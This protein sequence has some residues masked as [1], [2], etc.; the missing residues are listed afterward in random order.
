MQEKILTVTIHDCEVQTFRVGGHGGQKVN[1]TSSGVR[2]IHHP[3]NARG[4]C[5]EH[6]EQSRNKRAAFVKMA[7]SLQFKTWVGQVT[8]NLKTPSQI[9]AEVSADMD[10]SNLRVENKKDGQWVITE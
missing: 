5:R 10:P 2:V 6:R 9:E 8:G 1:K 4:E 3:S 7:E